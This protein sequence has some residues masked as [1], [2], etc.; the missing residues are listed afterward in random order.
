[1]SS[2]TKADAQDEHGGGKGKQDVEVTVFAPRVTE[3]R[4][5]TWDKHL[6]VGAAAQ[7]AATA[8]GYAAGTPTLA[9]D[10][11]ALDRDKQLVAAHVRDGDELDLVDTGGGV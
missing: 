10:D 2:E 7:E 6:T 9:K 5:F 3:G 4:V 11:V 8:F 1:M